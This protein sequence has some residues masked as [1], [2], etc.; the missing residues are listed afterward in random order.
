MFVDFVV[1]ATKFLF[2]QLIIRCMGVTRNNCESLI[3]RVTSAYCLCHRFTQS[4]LQFIVFYSTVYCV[5]YKEMCSSVLENGVSLESM[6]F[7]GQ[8]LY[9]YNVFW[10]VKFSVFQPHSIVCC[11]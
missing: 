4:R 1:P 7:K 6:R 8:N 2:F 5:I 11:F 3:L 10:L 9:L